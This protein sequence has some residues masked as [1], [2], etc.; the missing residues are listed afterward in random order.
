MSAK[1]LDC[2]IFPCIDC[3]LYTVNHS[4]VGG[5]NTVFLDFKTPSVCERLSC[6]EL[7]TPT[8]T[9]R[10]LVSS[11]TATDV[12]FLRQVLSF[13]GVMRVQV[14]FFFNVAWICFFLIGSSKEMKCGKG[15]SEVQ[16]EEPAVRLQ[17]IVQL[18]PPPDLV[19]D[20]QR[21][22]VRPNFWDIAVVMFWGSYW[23]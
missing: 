13:S 10:G 17:E 4:L 8:E 22:K 21:L 7:N 20:H 3:Q 2:W 9:P 6:W 19:V 1:M 11:Y 12:L 14:F 18:P 15:L 16:A 23:Q 5:G